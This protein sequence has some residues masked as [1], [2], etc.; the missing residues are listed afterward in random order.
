MLSFFSPMVVIVPMLLWLLVIGPLVLY[1]VAR[2]R[3][4]RE[5]VADPQLG[6]KVAVDYFKML[7]FQLLLLGGVV[8]LWTII[9]KSSADK[10]ELYRVAFGFLVPGGLVFGVHTA[11]LRRTNDDYFPAVRRLFSGYNLLV[12]GLVGF[13]ALVLGCQALFAKGSSGDVG[14]MFLAAVLV[15]G[16][17]WAGTAVQFARTVL[18][19]FGA[20]GG[21]PADV[22]P[23][24]APQPPA[25]Q[26]PAGPQLP[27]LSSGSFPPIEPKG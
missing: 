9:R 4:H 23:P 21:P 12:T 11:M 13:A 18:A 6:A 22:M 26:A 17:A 24:Q 25:A 5:P 2:W 15:Y 16:G 8:L 19:D 7:A 10:G 1:P 27:S 3:A 20:A 14:R